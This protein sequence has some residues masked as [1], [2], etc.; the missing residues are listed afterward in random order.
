MLANSK[1]QRPHAPFAALVCLPVDLRLYVQAGK[2]AISVDPR[3]NTDRM[4]KNEWPAGT[5]HTVPTNHCLTRLVG[6]PCSGL[7][8][9]PVEHVVG[10]LGE[11]QVGI[12]VGMHEE[13]GVCLKIR[14]SI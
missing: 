11:R 10:L 5:L 12:D 1:P 7:Q 4:I 2:P 8:A 6:T 13:M 9:F 3:V 14:N